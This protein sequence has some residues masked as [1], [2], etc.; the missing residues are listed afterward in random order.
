MPA[1]CSKAELLSRLL[2]ESSP[3]KLLHLQTSRYRQDGR[4]NNRPTAA[5]PINRAWGARDSILFLL[6]RQHIVAESEHDISEQYSREGGRC[7]EDTADV[8][9]GFAAEYHVG[10][11]AEWGKCGC[12]YGEDIEWARLG[13]G[14]FYWLSFAWRAW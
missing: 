11:A 2:A 1:T 7:R 14:E 12:H 13:S 4:P 3:L 9:A 10:S 6:V 5:A 8:S